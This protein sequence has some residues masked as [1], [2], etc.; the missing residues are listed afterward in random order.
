MK[1][2]SLFVTLGLISLMGAF[3]P[4][5]AQEVD[6]VPTAEES[7]M[8]EGDPTAEEPTLG[9]DEV[10]T[11]EEPTLIEGDP[12]AEDITPEEEPKAEE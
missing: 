9:V 8:M 6:E 4:V 5:N 12:T 11:A 2:L 3:A 7:T 10:P 1:N